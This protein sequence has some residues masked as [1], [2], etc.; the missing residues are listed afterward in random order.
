MNNDFFLPFAS[1]QRKCFPCAHLHHRSMAPPFQLYKSQLCFQ[2]RVTCRIPF[3]LCTWAHKGRFLQGHCSSISYTYVSLHTWQGSFV[4]CARS[5]DVASV[6]SKLEMHCGSCVCC[7]VRGKAVHV[8]GIC[9]LTTHGISFQSTEVMGVPYALTSVC[10]NHHH[11]HGKISAV[12][13]G[14]L[15]ER[16]G[17]YV[18]LW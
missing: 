16:L 5:S 1:M 18:S 12:L 15:M 7:T 9:I 17:N 11:S 6:F 4:L 13:R 2:L 8:E 3:T 14:G 10:V